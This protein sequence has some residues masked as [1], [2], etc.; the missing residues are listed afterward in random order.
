MKRPLEEKQRRMRE[1]QGRTV[2]RGRRRDEV[3]VPES[4]VERA[5]KRILAH[6]LLERGW[7]FAQVAEEIMVPVDSLIAWDREGRP[8][9]GKP[10]RSIGMLAIDRKSHAAR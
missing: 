4:V 10:F 1:R 7:S 3:A 8:L 6:S 5:R 2:R 9:A